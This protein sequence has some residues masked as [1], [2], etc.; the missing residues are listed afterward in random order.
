MRIACRP[1]SLAAMSLVSLAQSQNVY[2]NDTARLFAMVSLAGATWMLPRWLR[3]CET[4][5]RALGPAELED[6]PDR[7]L[8]GRDQLISDQ[9]VRRQP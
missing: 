4:S 3:G 5:E 7:P 2:S 1:R 9:G 6:R 8:A